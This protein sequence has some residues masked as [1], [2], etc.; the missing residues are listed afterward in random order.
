MERPISLLTLTLILS[1]LSTPVITSAI[2]CNDVINDLL[3]C[4]NYVQ[5]GGSVPGNCCAGV[6]QVMSSASTRADRQTACGCIKNVAN[7]AGYG[8]GFNR[9]AAIPGQCGINMPYKLTPNMDCS[10][11][12]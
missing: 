1:L 9:A 4:A 6:R 7:S 3:P 5:K 11:I 8:A 12:N 10:K 2:T